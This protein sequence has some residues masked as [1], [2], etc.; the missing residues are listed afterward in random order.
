MGTDRLDLDV[1]DWLPR[2]GPSSSI[3]HTK[4][5]ITEIPPKYT[6]GHVSTPAAAV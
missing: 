6:A 2:I 1:W 3:A 5:E 4:K